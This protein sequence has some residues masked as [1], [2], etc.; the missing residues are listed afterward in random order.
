MAEIP[1]W[2]DI[3]CA[4]GEKDQFVSTSSYR[5]HPSG[6]TSKGLEVIRCLKCGSVV[7]PAA[8]E[9]QQRR[10][11]LQRQLSELDQADGSL[12]RDPPAPSGPS[13]SR[14]S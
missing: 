8:M 12:T 5:W 3:V 11:S 7:D 14:R 10:Q 1:R 4:C 6:G 9:R 2:H 13:V